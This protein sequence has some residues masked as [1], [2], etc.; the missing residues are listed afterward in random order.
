MELSERREDKVQ[1]A[2]RRPSILII[3]APVILSIQHPLLAQWREDWSVFAVLELVLTTYARSSFF[4]SIWYHF[5]TLYIR[6]LCFS[7]CAYITSSLPSPT[8]PIQP[9]SQPL[10]I[11]QFHI[12]KVQRTVSE[13]IHSADAPRKIFSLPEFLLYARKRLPS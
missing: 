5:L 9:I 13:G 12:P 3:D 6:N 8:Q 11:G 2:K 7:L 1:T 10:T 4:K